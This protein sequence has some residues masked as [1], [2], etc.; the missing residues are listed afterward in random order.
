[1]AK[2][3]TL[4]TRTHLESFSYLDGRPCA[5]KSLPAEDHGL[6]F[7]HGE[8]PGGY[9][10]NGARE[11]VVYE[12]DGVYH[13]LY[14]AAGKEGW[15]TALATSCDLIHWERKGLLLDLGKEGSGDEG[16]ASSAW[17]VR[18][19]GWWHIFYLAS[20]N[21]S[22]APDF[23]PS[24]PYMTYKARARKLAGPW[25]KQYAVTPFTTVPGTWHSVTAS[26][27]YV[28]EHEG[29]FLQ[30][31]SGSHELPAFKGHNAI[32]LPP[33][34]IH[35]TL[36]IAR[37]RDLDGAWTVDPEP[38]APGPEQIENSSVYYEPA[39]GTWFLFTNH[40]GEGPD[41]AMDGK[42]HDYTDAIWVYWSKDPNRWNPE[43]K[44]VVL[45]GGNC[46]WAKRNIGMPAVIPHE[47]RLAILY[48][49]VEGDRIDHMKRD[50]GLCWLDLPL[51]PPR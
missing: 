41:P 2:T 46:T 51:E 11:A 12:E 44:A 32:D 37:T 8:G 5:R 39:N 49:A 18:H 42:V 26:P 19:D 38:L 9:D 31:I 16:T 13:L 15:L 40:V 45:D 1:M 21:A 33:G 43:D 48:D 23:I 36:G 47:G 3:T 17:A 14:D 4:T 22:P 24:F 7:R 28:V 29:E 50:I 30:F 20:P 27:G 34:S 10:V 35:R 25:E 6:V